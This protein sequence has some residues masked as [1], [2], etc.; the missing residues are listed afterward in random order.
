MQ[1]KQN[2]S[3]NT[4]GKNISDKSDKVTTHFHVMSGFHGC[5]PEMNETYE[6]L[7]TAKS[8]LKDTVK[9][10][11]RDGNRFVGQNNYYECTKKEGFLGD[12]IELAECQEKECLENMEND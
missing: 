8:F 3:Q 10:L 1:T 4:E 9:E 5:L 12:Y 6:D 2:K 11:R 7:K